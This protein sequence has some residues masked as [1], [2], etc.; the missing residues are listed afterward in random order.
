MN[1]GQP[2]FFQALD[3]QLKAMPI[4]DWKIYLRWHLLR[5]FAPALSSNFVDEN[6]NFYGRTL[7]GAKELQPRWKR[8]V[9]STDRELGQALGQKYVQR[10]F[11]RR[12]RR[13]RTRWWRTW[14]RHCM[15]I[16]KRF[17]G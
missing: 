1:V 3:K 14:S 6:F 4:A 10:R 16:S 12:P 2:E 5:T 13:A 7:T 9:I 8:C 11:R 15:P 17:P